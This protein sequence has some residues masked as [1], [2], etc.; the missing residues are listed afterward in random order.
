MSDK[1]WIGFDLGGTKMLAAVFDENYKD[2][3][4]ERKKTKGAQGP[5]AGLE[6]V[7]KCIYDAI[8]SSGVTLDSIAG[9]GIGCPGPIQPKKGILLQAPN[10]GWKNVPVAES[11]TKEF[12]KP[13]V[14]IN[15]VDAGVYGEYLFG[16]GQGAE[17]LLGVFPGT[18][19]G[20]GF[21]QNGV[22]LQ[23]AK[24]SCMEIGHI[25]TVPEGPIASAGLPGSLEAVASRLAMSALIAQA[26]YR[27]QAPTVASSA[28]TDLANIRSGLLAD[29][30]K[31]DSMVEDIMTRA[32]VQLGKSIAGFVHMLAPEKI[33]LGGGLVEAMPEFFSKKIKEG[34][35]SWLLPA[36]QDVSEVVVA[37]L[38]DD[39]GIRGSAAWARKNFDNSENEKA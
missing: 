28:G 17:S 20:G 34:M 33:V 16:A 29:A 22:I 5:E 31:K 11:L 36:Y 12:K 35:K 2:L 9:I 3:G 15:D 19:I 1:N 18:G 10:L 39:A 4:R 30:L 27:G 13:V 32:V 7:I 26:S 14:V 38:G 24:I 8:E 23:G 37:K 25:P 6:R 21:V